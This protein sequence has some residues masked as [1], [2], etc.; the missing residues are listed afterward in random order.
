MPT[1][2]IILLRKSEFFVVCDPLVCISVV[3]PICI[4]IAVVLVVVVLVFE[5]DFSNGGDEGAIFFGDT[6]L[7]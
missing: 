3:L 2:C 5:M 7:I 1:A 6:S 4:G